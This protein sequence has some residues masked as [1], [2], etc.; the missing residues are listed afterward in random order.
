[1]LLVSALNADDQL[2]W[3]GLVESKIRLLISNLE[4]NPHISLA[5]VNPKCYDY[6]EDKIEA[7]DESETTSKYKGPCSMWFIGLEFMKTDNLNVDLTDN[8]QSFTNSIHK[9]AVSLHYI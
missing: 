2:E 1:M 9:H 3:T 8:I 7:K 6:E 5:H 4:R